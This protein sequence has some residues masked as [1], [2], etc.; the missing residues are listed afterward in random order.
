[1]LWQLADKS[2]SGFGAGLMLNFLAERNPVL[3][4]LYAPEI[5]YQL[6]GRGQKVILIMKKLLT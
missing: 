6:N 3:H 1:M 2:P 4:Q 5:Q